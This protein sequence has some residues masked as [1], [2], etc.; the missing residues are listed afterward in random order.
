[1]QG[2]KRVDGA[3]QPHHTQHKT[4]KYRSKAPEDSKRAPAEMEVER[5]WAVIPGYSMEGG[6]L[7]FEYHFD[8]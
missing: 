7:G 3:Y 5:R 6:L 8:L 4:G 1:M 2:L